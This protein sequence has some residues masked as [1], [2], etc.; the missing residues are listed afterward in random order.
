MNDSE[1]PK[2]LLRAVTV[3]DAVQVTS[4]LTALG[5]VMPDGPD[6]VIAHWRA[7][8]VDNPAMASHA[9]DVALG[10]VLEDDGAIKGFF[11]NIPQISWLGDRPVRISSARAWAIDPAYRTETPRLCA[12]FFGQKDI[13]VVLISSAN[14][15]AGK[16]CLAFGAS[17]MPQPGYAD[18][19]Y[20]IVDAPGFL[21]AA[22][23][24]K[25]RGKVMARLL[26]MLGAVPLD[27]TMRI[28]GRRPYGALNHVSVVPLD[29]IDDSFDGL[30]ARKRA[31][32]PATL[33]ASRDAAT[34]RWYFG[35]GAGRATTRVLRY[36]RDGA[37]NGY[38]V[39]VRE[40]APAVGL[41][42]LKIADLFVDGDDAKV[43][44]AL[45][46]AAYEYAISQRCHVLEVIGLAAAMRAH[47][48]KTKPFSRTMATFP[49][50]FK[51][52]NADLTPVL[53]DADGWAVTA[54]DGDTALL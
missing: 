53:A 48:M 23:R 16:R 51:A 1:N 13:D 19:Q 12:A 21:T 50:F 22:F 10:W 24:K 38:A 32:L 40:D 43:T 17:P 15:P 29:G 31:Q 5:L 41:K 9:P 25:G 30:W 52:L 14:P 3:D 26:G 39:L 35:L 54:Y 8:W 37:L 36:D 6:A 45:L 33:L 44:Q 18:I 11:G 4:F 20:W 49:F 7:L 34:L 47:L 42:R 46:A 28:K 2:G 27:F